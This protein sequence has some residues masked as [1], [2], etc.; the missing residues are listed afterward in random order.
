MDLS[1]LAFSAE[2]VEMHLM[3]P[4]TNQVLTT[5]AGEPMTLLVVG[6]DSEEC[7]KVDREITDRRLKSQAFG[8]KIK[9]SAEQIEAE[10]FERTI[11]CIVGFKNI[12]VKSDPLEYSKKS[13][14]DLL[15]TFPWLRRQ[16][17]EFIDDQA[18][19]IKAL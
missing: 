11:A 16:V 12:I 14:K 7:R 18:N 5:D 10:S 13:V 3:H 19:F 17:E 2:A 6:T 9:V 8:R 15:K 4:V 1:Q